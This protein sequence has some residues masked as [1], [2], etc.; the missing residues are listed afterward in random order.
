MGTLQ[1]NSAVVLAI[2]SHITKPYHKEV[3]VYL[4][5]KQNKTKLR[6]AEKSDFSL[7]FANKE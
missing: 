3:K 2:A 1:T 7:L 5:T 6:A 4:K